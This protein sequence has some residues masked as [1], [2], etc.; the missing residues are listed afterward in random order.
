MLFEITVRE[1]VYQFKFGIGFLRDIEKT[2]TQLINGIE[3][4]VGL[5]YAVAGLIDRD[6]VE[7]ANVLNIAN[8]GMNPRIT[9]ALIDEYIDNEDTDIEQLCEDVL[10]FLKRANAMKTRVQALLNEV[11]KEKAKM[12]AEA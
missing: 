5:T 11:E 2:H 6:M 9:P 1:T 8:K 12:M 4:E 3:K 7:V 10:G